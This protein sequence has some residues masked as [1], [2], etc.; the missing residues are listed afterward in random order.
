M[1]SVGG[2]FIHEDDGRDVPSVSTGAAVG[3]KRT[4]RM[5]TEGRAQDQDCTALTK[6]EDNTARGGRLMAAAAAVRVCAQRNTLN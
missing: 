6:A 3:A 2:Y 1:F 5:G 4:R